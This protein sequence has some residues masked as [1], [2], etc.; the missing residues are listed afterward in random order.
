MDMMKRQFLE[1]VTHPSAMMIDTCVDF[2][3][4]SVFDHEQMAEVSARFYIPLGVIQNPLPARG[5]WD[6]IPKVHPSQLEKPM[7]PQQ[8]LNTTPVDMTKWARVK[9]IPVGELDKATTDGWRVL[10][11]SQ[12]NGQYLVGLD[13][14]E[15]EQRIQQAIRSLEN[16]LA[17]ASKRADQAETKLVKLEQDH[18]RLKASFDV[19][20]QRE[21]AY[22]EWNNNVEHKAQKMER[23]LGI[24][25]NRIGSDAF[26]RYLEEAGE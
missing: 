14:A 1:R 13:K 25:R 17:A 3:R 23:H 15:A 11:V 6:D 9:S 12:L 5:V 21:G 26:N 24:I 10:G 19:V 22:N 7:A 18:F 16:R 4:R 2:V 8:Q 20:K